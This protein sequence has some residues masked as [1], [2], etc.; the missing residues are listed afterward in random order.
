MT[1]L[2]E[3]SFL[4][5]FSCVLLLHIG[6]ISGQKINTYFNTCFT[7]STK[8]ENIDRREQT[9]PPC[10]GTIRQKKS[11]KKDHQKYPPKKGYQ[12]NKSL[13]KVISEAK[14]SIDLE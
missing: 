8:A 3:L 5:R 4:H 12:E 10:L 14:I 7:H 9:L 2:S 13:K 11:L 1:E 6:V